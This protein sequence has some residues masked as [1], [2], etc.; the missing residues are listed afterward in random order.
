MSHR[1]FLM[2]IGCALSIGAVACSDDPVSPS[3]V[4]GSYAA[5]FFQVTENGTTTNVLSAGGT[6][7]LELTASGT[8]TGQIHVP[9]IAGQPAFDADLAGTWAIEDETVQLQHNA[10]TFLRDMDLVL[11]GD[12]LVGDRTFGPTRIR[13]ELT[14]R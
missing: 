9:S 3:E 2:A 12:K 8:T 5:S 6:V 4:Q 13:I 10:D 1:R 14:R 11:D 7:T